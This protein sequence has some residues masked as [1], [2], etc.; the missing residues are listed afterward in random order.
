M[1]DN[2]GGHGTIL[3]IETHEKTLLDE[4]NIEI[5]H[6]VPNLPETNLLDLGVWDPL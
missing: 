2:C 5:I 6:Q 1:M 3:A 4:F